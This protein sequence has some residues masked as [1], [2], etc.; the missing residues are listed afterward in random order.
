M[1]K[2]F[3]SVKYEFTQDEIRELGK[4]L[5]V[6]GARLDEVKGERAA[7]LADF[8]A[9][10]E[11]IAGRQRELQF[12]INNGYKL[13]EVE[14]MTMKHTPRDG[15]K[16]ILRIDTNTVLREEPMTARELQDSF[17]WREP[18]EDDKA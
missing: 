2:D 5:A 13:I 4:S 15:I 9:R 7:V 11:A 18:G 14:V 3:E 6:E 12:Q 17:G 1:K 16:Q 10:T 8:K